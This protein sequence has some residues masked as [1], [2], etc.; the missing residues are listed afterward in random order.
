MKVNGKTRQS[1]D[2]SDMIWSVP[3]TLAYLSGLVELQPGDLVFTGTPEGVGPV[4]AG[5]LV[6]GHVE[7]VGDLAIRYA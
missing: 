7:G 6:E 1:G 2:L 4:V 5:D 3:E